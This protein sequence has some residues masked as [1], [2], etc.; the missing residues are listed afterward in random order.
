ME[1]S[2]VNKGRASAG[3]GSW[4]ASRCRCVCISWLCACGDDS[5]WV[6]LALVVGLAGRGAGSAWVAV[7]WGGVT[8]AGE[9]GLIDGIGVLLVGVRLVAG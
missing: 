6:R 7:L 8:I 9:A 4:A 5:V 1:L 3:R 2:M